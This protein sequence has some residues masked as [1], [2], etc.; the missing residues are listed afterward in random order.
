M[1][2]LYRFSHILPPQHPPRLTVPCCRPGWALVILSWC[3]QPM[4]LYP[5]YTTP[6][7]SDV[8]PLT[9]VHTLLPLLSTPPSCINRSRSTIQNRQ[10]WLSGSTHVCIHICLNFPAMLTRRSVIVINDL[11]IPP[12]GAHWYATQLDLANDV[13]AC[14]IREVG[15]EWESLLCSAGLRIEIII[16]PYPPQRK[17]RPHVID[18]V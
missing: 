3:W 4:T 6:G 8:T 16:V 18:K 17:I 13:Y 7:T 15:A 5:A 14:S 12:T 2:Y 10:S 9:R 11:V 1:T